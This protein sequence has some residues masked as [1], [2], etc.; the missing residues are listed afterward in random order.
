MASPAHV[1]LAAALLVIGVALP[2]CTPP[3]ASPPDLPRETQ[4]PLAAGGLTSEEIA[5]S[6]P[7]VTGL[8]V[9]ETSHSRIAGT[10]PHQPEVCPLR[11]DSLPVTDRWALL[12]ARGD[13]VE[14][15][16]VGTWAYGDGI[17]DAWQALVAAAG[18]CDSAVVETVTVPERPTAS[19]D[20]FLLRQ[21]IRGDGAPAL[22]TSASFRRVEDAIQMVEVVRRGGEAESASSA[23]AGASAA[24]ASLIEPAA[25][26]YREA[27]RRI[28]TP[29]SFPPRDAW[30]L[31]EQMYGQPVAVSLGD[32]YI[33]GAAA[34]WQ[35]NAVDE[36]LHTVIDRLGAQAYWDTQDGESVQGCLRGFVSPIG[37]WPN[38]ITLA[39]AG[40]HTVSRREDTFAGERLKPGVD[41]VDDGP[42]QGQLVH[43]KEAARDADVRLVALSTGGNDLGFKEIVTECV[44]AFATTSRWSP[45][46]CRDSDLVRQAFSPEGLEALR[47][48]VAGAVERTITAMRDSGYDDDR[49]TLIVQGYPSPLPPSSRMRYDEAGWDRVLLG[50][51]GFW[52][53]DLDF[54]EESLPRM[55]DAVFAGVADAE[56]ATGK[57]V[58]TVDTERLF[59]GRRLCENGAEVADDVPRD[60]LA[61]TAE[62]VAAI[63]AVEGLLGTFKLG[64]SLHPNYFG[65]LALQ[66]CLR[67][68]WNDGQPRSGECMAP[69]DWDSASRDGP[70]QGVRFVPAE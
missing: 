67:Q 52:N 23:S 33:S 19:D 25:Q 2:A 26:R 8:P 46:Y 14:L 32:S 38:P 16:R 5:A 36:A 29:A 35:G 58:L 20:S 15:S 48:N 13:G 12:L 40:S 21:A 57:E 66:D 45:S 62:R 27:F 9:T 70:D 18:S 31:P 42:L 53:A 47:N 7:S 61:A 39:C 10:R 64:E 24:V 68:A 55:N 4:L 43:L 28:V 6:L 59:E 63:F 69:V 44:A 30:E 34:R 60:R 37:F 54:L 56:R 3:A 1:A 41:F 17:D 49:W 65:Q 51:C 11:D 22:A 50:G